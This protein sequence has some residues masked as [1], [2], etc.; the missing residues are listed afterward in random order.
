[1][2]CLT[3]VSTMLGPWAGGFHQETSPAGQRNCHVFHLVKPPPPLSHHQDL[4]PLPL[5][6]MHFLELLVAVC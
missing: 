5:S 4:P 2:M 3:A 1:M 6:E